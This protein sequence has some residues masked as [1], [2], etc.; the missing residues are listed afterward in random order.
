LKW[1]KWGDYALRSESF[2]I[3]KALVKGKWVYVLW[4]L[5]NQRI[6]NY[7]S[8]ADAKA[9]A[10]SIAQAKPEGARDSFTSQEQMNEPFSDEPAELPLFDSETGN[11]AG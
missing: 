1:E 11:P 10:T 8:A 7:P 2:S 3:S 9:A 5:P 4:Q 6:G